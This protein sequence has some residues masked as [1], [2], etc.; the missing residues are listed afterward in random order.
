MKLSWEDTAVIFLQTVIFSRAFLTEGMWGLSLFDLGG[1][2]VKYG[3]QLW[4]IS[5]K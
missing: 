4:K 3:H 1:D 5:A 2:L